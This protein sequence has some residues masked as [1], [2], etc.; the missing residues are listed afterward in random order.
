MKEIPDE[1]ARLQANRVS[2]SAAPSMPVRRL[3]TIREVDSQATALVRFAG[4]MS[5]LRISDRLS[6]LIPYDSRARRHAKVWY[7]DARTLL[8]TVLP[9]RRLEGRCPRFLVIETTNICNADCVF[10]AYQYQRDFRTG[11]GVMGDDVFERALTGYRELGGTRLSLTPVVGDPLVDK[12]LIPRIRRATEAGFEVSFHTN[13]ILLNRVNVE[14]LIT[15]GIHE[16]V[17]ST[18]PFDKEAHEQLYRTRHYDDLLAG[19]R[20]LLEVRNRLNHPLRITLHFRS[21]LPV[22]DLLALPDYRDVIEPLLR[23]E[24]RAAVGALI[25]GFDSW[26]GQICEEDLPGRMDMAIP[27]RLKHRPCALTFTP[28]VLWDGKVRAC[29]CYF[30]KLASRDAKDDL[31]IGDLSE[32]TLREIW[33]GEAL[34]R[35]RRRFVR[36]DLPPLCRSCTMYTAT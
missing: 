33:E 13:G 31:Y 32:S 23:P 17:V 4:T 27:P 24:E 21:H 15:S 28:Q 29:P 5:R 14:A 2:A 16:L 34:R 22:N 12:R 10:C 1:P 3:S 26:G 19:V 25:S 6:R 18:S 11:K 8:R 36:G 7:A 30:G 9:W 35:V 20:S